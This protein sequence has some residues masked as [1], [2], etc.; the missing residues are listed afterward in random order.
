MKVCF[1]GMKNFF[2]EEEIE[3]IKEFTKFLQSEVPLKKEIL[4]DFLNKRKG[5]MTTG[6]R[7]T[8]HHIKVL[9]KDRLLIDVLRTF[10]H[11]WVHEFQHQKLGL[12]EKQKIQDIGGPEENMANILA[13]IFLKQFQKLYPK[14]NKII[15]NEN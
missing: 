10:S 12:K 13:G 15:Y 4:V 6:S 11:E 9:A 7:E 5:H 1:K 14:Y 8:H 3:V 2:S